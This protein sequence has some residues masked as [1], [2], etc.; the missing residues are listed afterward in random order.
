[1]RGKGH[2]ELIVISQFVHHIY[3]IHSFLAQK[4]CSLKA[5]I[6]QIHRITHYHNIKSFNAWNLVYK[7]SF[8]QCIMEAF[9]S[10]DLSLIHTVIQNVESLPLIVVWDTIKHGII[11]TTTSFISWNL[12]IFLNHSYHRFRY[13]MKPPIP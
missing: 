9:N 2:Y 4:T 8:I 3:H 5:Y 6:H 7:R 11:H 1:M 12:S 13:N 10:W